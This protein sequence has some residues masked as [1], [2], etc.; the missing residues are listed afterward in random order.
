MDEKVE[1]LGGGV[2]EKGRELRG[3]ECVVGVKG[4][5]KLGDGFIGGYCFGS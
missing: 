3:R 4:L 2:E 5:N 1:V